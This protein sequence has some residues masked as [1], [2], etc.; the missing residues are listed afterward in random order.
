MTLISHIK[1]N[2][3]ISFDVLN[4]DFGNLILIPLSKTCYN[5]IPTGS[6]N[7]KLGKF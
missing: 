3:Q 5:A 4:V 6:G 1:K 7:R 2:K